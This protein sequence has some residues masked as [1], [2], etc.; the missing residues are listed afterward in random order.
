MLNIDFTKIILNNVLKSFQKT[1]VL[2]IP[3]LFKKGKEIFNKFKGQEIFNRYALYIKYL[4]RRRK[5]LLQRKGIMYYLRCKYEESVEKYK[6]DYNLKKE[7]FKRYKEERSES[8]FCY[9]YK[10]LLSA[11]SSEIF[12]DINTEPINEKIEKI[13]LLKKKYEKY[14]QHVY[15]DD[16]LS[17]EIDTVM[18]EIDK[19]IF[20][21]EALRIFTEFILNLKNL[22]IN[23]LF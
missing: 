12:E 11:F 22:V 17:N 20:K 9:C 4:E 14:N 16:N 23:Q 6:E 2:K 3:W 8:D 21:D 19:E 18:S 7:A 5:L 10:E 13:S 1:L 15:M